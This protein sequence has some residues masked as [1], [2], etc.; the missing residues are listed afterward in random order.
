[1]LIRHA[2]CGTLRQAEKKIV[3]NLSQQGLQPPIHI[4]PQHHHDLGG[5]DTHSSG[6]SWN[7]AVFFWYQIPE[8][9]F[10]VPDTIQNQLLV[11]LKG[12][13]ED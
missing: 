12:Q 10:P 7:H 3:K 1:M 4:C 11:E 8:F 13:K 6:S 2:Q 9:F 5:V